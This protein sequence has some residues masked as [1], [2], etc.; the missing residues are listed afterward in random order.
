[1]NIV[2][3][4]RSKGVANDHRINVSEVYDAVNHLN[5]CENQGICGSSSSLYVDRFSE[6]NVHAAILITY[7]FVPWFRTVLFKRQHYYTIIPISKGYH[8]NLGYSENYQFIV[9]RPV[10]CKIIDL[11]VISTK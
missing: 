7:M 6:L 2:I 11:I 9:L 4:S 3:R 5:A 1:V 10:M 8:G